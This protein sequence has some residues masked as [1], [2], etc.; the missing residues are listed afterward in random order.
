MTVFTFS[1]GNGLALFYILELSKLSKPSRCLRSA[2]N[3][4][5][6]R[7]IF[8]LYYIINIYLA[9]CPT[10]ID[11]QKHLPWH[12]Q[13][14]CTLIVQSLSCFKVTPSQILESLKKWHRLFVERKL[15]VI[16]KPVIQ[17]IGPNSCSVCIH[18]PEW[19]RAESEKSLHIALERCGWSTKRGDSEQ[20]SDDED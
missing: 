11:T 3:S 4:I 8:L 1:I 20:D 5:L 2:E 6:D 18:E 13:K 7:K 14:K 16:L 19:E 12:R 15:I 9:L 10:S 17:L